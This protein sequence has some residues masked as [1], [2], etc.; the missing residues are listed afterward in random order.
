MN[1]RNTLSDCAGIGSNVDS[2]PSFRPSR[3][4]GLGTTKM[5]REPLVNGRFEMTTRARD[6]SGSRKKQFR[7]SEGH[8]VVNV[9]SYSRTVSELKHALSKL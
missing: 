5:N 4:V 1:R 3:A 2:S 8:S 9:D 7:F 6:L